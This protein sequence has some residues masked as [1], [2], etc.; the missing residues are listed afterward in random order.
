[1]PPRKRKTKL[2]PKLPSRVRKKRPAKKGARARQHRPELWGLAAVALGV[3]LGSVLYAGWNGGY[4][5]RWLADGLDAVIG[6]AAYAMPVA[7]VVL[8]LLTV[9]K[10][11]LVDVRPFRVGLAV[12]AFGLMTTLGRDHG[13]YVG[14]LLGDAFG[15]AIG[16]TGSTILGS[17]LL[18]VGALLLSGAS[19]GAILRRSGH[20][21][22]RVAV[23]ARER[24]PV[25]ASEPA[26][27]HASRR[28]P[29]DGEEAYPDVVGDEHR[30]VPMPALLAP[31]PL[32]QAEPSPLLAEPAPL[33]EDPPTL[34]DEVTAEHA[35]Y[36]LPDAG[37]LHVS[38]ERPDTAGETSA[39]V[40][41][42]LVQTLA[43]FGVEANVIGQISG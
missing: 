28:P 30:A 5:G 33:H 6:A 23:R 3:F 4:V 43:H 35:Q 7:L 16:T 22:R 2:R 32:V 18:L 14:R 20:T 34:F 39:R 41:E 1:M 42:L 26:P 38:P 25:R 11:A 36:R 12:V 24:R 29:V 40:A 15:V 19:L 27:H 37:V 13:G 9:A 21:A 8:G 31:S 17:L 10:S